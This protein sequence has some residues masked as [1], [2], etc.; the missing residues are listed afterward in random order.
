[1]RKPFQEKFGKFKMPEDSE[2]ERRIV[3]SDAEGYWVAIVTYSVD[4]KRRTI[5]NIINFSE[6]SPSWSY[7]IKLWS[8]VRKLCSNSSIEIWTDFIGTNAPD[9]HSLSAHWFW[10]LLQ[11]ER[12]LKGMR[13]MWKRALVR[14]HLG[15][16]TPNLGALWRLP[17]GIW[18][19][20]WCN[21]CWEGASTI[22][23]IILTA[24][25]TSSTEIPSQCDPWTKSTRL[26]SQTAITD[27][28]VRDDSTRIILD[29]MTASPT[30]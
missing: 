2:E 4:A 10:V 16:R 23:F 5:I 14:G 27:S 9:G 25:W 1:M 24:H 30:V 3:R 8:M 6:E 15:V 26:Q 11:D 17:N 18:F 28:A 19:G 20:G 13:G 21:H 12:G 22:L 29:V 7:P